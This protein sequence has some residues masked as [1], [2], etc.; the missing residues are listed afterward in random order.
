MLKHKNLRNTTIAT[1]KGNLTVDAKGIVTGLNVEDEEAFGSRYNLF[2]YII[3]PSTPKETKV[4]KTSSKTPSKPST[5]TTSKV[6]PKKTTKKV[7][8]KKT[9]KN[10]ATKATTKKSKD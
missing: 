1:I 5:K 8:P 7:T 3:E 4:A 6:A 2:E 10:V 9:T